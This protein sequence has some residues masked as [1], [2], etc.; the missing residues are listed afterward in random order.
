MKLLGLKP[1]RY[2][3]WFEVV[4]EEGRVLSK[5]DL[6]RTFFH[7]AWLVLKHGFKFRKRWRTRVRICQKCPIYDRSLRRCRPYTGSELGCGC[8]VP[9]IALFEDRCWGG[10][11]GLNHQGIGWAIVADERKGHV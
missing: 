6:A 2:L 7:A 9:L 8:W 10:E 1:N 11:V 4:K 3:Q 5:A